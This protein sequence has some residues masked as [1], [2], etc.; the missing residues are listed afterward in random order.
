MATTTKETEKTAPVKNGKGKTKTTN[1]DQE[2]ASEWAAF[3]RSQGPQRFC[4]SLD[5][6]RIIWRKYRDLV[7]GDEFPEPFLSAYKDLYPD[8]EPGVDLGNID[9]EEELLEA[10][11]LKPNEPSEPRKSLTLKEIRQLAHTLRRGSDVDA[12]LA[13]SFS[14]DESDDAE[15]GELAKYQAIYRRVNQYSDDGDPV[16]GLITSLVLYTTIGFVSYD[17]AV[18]RLEE[19]RA[20]WSEYKQ[21][22]AA[23]REDEEIEKLRNIT[24]E[25]HAPA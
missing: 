15:L 14:I 5:V 9:G 6:A 19:A 25:V 1:V 12:A 3:R 4:G 7:E 8:I 16:G 13:A 2:T 20:N 21:V 17:D 24:R 11:I 22:T 18:R 23:A 10:G